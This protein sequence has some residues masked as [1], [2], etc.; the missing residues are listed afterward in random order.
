MKTQQLE[1][2][3]SNK[4]EEDIKKARRKSTQAGALGP[5]RERTGPTLGVQ[6]GRRP[7][8]PCLPTRAAPPLPS[9]LHPG[10]Y[11]DETWVI[12]CRPAG[13]WGLGNS[14]CPVIATRAGPSPGQISGQ[15]ASS[16]FHAPRAQGPQEKCKPPRIQ[17]SQGN[18]LLLAPQPW[19]PTFVSIIR[20][21][22]LSI[23]P[24]DFGS[25]A[26]WW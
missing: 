2:K 26:T 9:A 10:T 6:D 18:E 21:W 8:P 7:S 25:S 14:C 17:A 16:L 12:G 24:S 20:L 11:K 5:G 4:T 15:E 23:S 1:I 19:S 22:F 13:G 3:L